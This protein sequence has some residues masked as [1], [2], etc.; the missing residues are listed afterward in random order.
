MPRKILAEHS[1]VRS[2]VAEVHRLATALE[3][4]KP[5][6]RLDEERRRLV[7]RAQDRLAIV[8]KLAEEADEV[9]RALAVESRCR[10]VEEQQRRAA[11]ELDDDRET[12]VCL[13]TLR[14]KARAS[15][16]S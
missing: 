13:D 8:G 7:N 4:Q 12:F 6:E 16:R 5:V 10:L 1:A 14:R 2:D 11:C 3:Q 9:L 15:E